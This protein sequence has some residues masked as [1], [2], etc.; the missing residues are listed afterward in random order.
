M[1]NIY[2]NIN[3]I[4]ITIPDITVANKYWFSSFP[5]PSCCGDT[6]HIVYLMHCPPVLTLS[7]PY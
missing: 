3:T 7:L 4:N 2:D 6:D 1:K 5:S